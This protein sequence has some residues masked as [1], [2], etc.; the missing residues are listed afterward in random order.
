MQ[1]DPHHDQDRAERLL[2]E[3]H[4]RDE[5][6]RNRAIRARQGGGKRH[7]HDQVPSFRMRGPRRG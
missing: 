1:R 4:A 5:E 3:Q 6:R 7:R 2:H